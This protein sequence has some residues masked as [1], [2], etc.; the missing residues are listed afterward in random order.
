MQDNRNPE[1]GIEVV[2]DR[3][4]HKYDAPEEPVRKHRQPRGY[5][6][7]WHDYFEDVASHSWDEGK[8][9]RS[10][11]A[12]GISKLFRKTSVT[13]KIREMAEKT[14]SQLD[15]GKISFSEWYASRI[16][17]AGNPFHAIV[18]RLTKYVWYAPKF[19]LYAHVEPTFV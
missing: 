16:C 5:I 18:K 19:G 15:L 6:D 9:F 7:N 13:P 4:K 12:E 1:E 17:R 11:I 10:L 14:S 8:P 3:F 2:W